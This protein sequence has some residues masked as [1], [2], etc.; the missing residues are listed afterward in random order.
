MVQIYWKRIV[1]ESDFS[2]SNFVWPTPGYKTITSPYGY[3]KAPTSGAG[4]FHEVLI[5]VLLRVL[6]S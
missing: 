3:T 1:L 2:N 6:K 5:L 4:V